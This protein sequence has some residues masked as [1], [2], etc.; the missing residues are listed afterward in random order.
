[1]RK[2]QRQG[3]HRS[4]HWRRRQHSVPGLTCPCARCKPMPPFSGRLLQQQNGQVESQA[5]ASC[6]ILCTTSSMRRIARLYW[7]PCQ[8]TPRQR[9]HTQNSACCARMP[10]GTSW[11]SGS[12]AAGS[13]SGMNSPLHRAHLQCRGRDRR[14]ADWLGV[15]HVPEHKRQP[16][17]RHHRRSCPTHRVSRSSCCTASPNA[18]STS[19][20]CAGG[21][22]AGGPA[23][24]ARVSRWS[25]QATVAH[26]P[27]APPRPPT[28]TCC[29]LVSLCTRKAWSL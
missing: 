7:L 13:G 8:Y 15:P 21:S 11:P 5:A 27:P 10:G 22:A 9:A 18:A 14:R 4:S 12:C 17:A 19:S 16:A 6:P 20:S 25:R 2:C 24:Q 1:M 23:L 3:E 26:V 28:H 29:C